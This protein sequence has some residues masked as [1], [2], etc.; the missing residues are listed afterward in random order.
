MR[1]VIFLFVF[2]L[3]V[4]MF[5]S[6]IN[7]F[8]RSIILGK[9]INC[10]V[11]GVDSISSGR[12]SD[13]VLILS[14]NPKKRF[15]DVISVPRD[16]R[17]SLPGLSIRKINQIYAYKYRKSKK[18]EDAAI[19]L[20]DEMANMFGM[21]IPYYFQLDFDGFKRI[22]DAIGGV[23]VRVDSAQDTISS[24][25][26][27]GSGETVLDGELAL[28]YV[29]ERIGDRADLDRILKQQEFLCEMFHKAGT[30]HILFGLPEIFSLLRNCVNTNLGLWDVLTSLY[31]FKDF[32]IS[33]I[34]LQLLP[35]RPRGSYWLLDAAG[36]Q[37]AFTLVLEGEVPDTGQIY[38][39]S[40][41]VVEIFNA[42]DI[43]GAAG[44]MRK[45]F[46]ERGFDVV[47]I[48]AYGAGSH[49]RKTVVIDRLGQPEK[50]RRVADTIGTK[51][52]LTKLDERRGV[53]VSVIIGEDLKELRQIWS[54]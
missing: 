15:L 47:K 39:Y 51:I 28:S 12:H 54:K 41:V 26:F 49:Y 25:T 3:A 32:K 9:R 23:K 20:R 45:V 30:H 38:T 52:V 48:G 31:E 44:R 46:V 21:E 35:G 8:T 2:I 18:D 43:S 53:D 5:F 27:T 6:F 36:V 10:L 34:R 14:Y 1:K 29:R 17:I 24:N 22:I 42:S 4:S 11:M 7:S 37:K 16:T 13:V 50:A 33:D 19:F 40:D